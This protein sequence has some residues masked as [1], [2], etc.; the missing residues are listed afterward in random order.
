MLKKI[1]I[2]ILIIISLIGIVISS[3]KIIEWKNENNKTEN[4]VQ[5]QKKMQK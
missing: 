1:I 3:N 2:S 4:Y 5:E